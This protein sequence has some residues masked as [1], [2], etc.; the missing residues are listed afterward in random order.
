MAYEDLLPHCSLMEIG[1]RLQVQV[2]ELETVIEI[3]EQLAGEK[4]L[5]GLPI[6]RQTLKESKSRR[7]KE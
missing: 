7:S 5:A 4:D 2:L 3:K 6:L 1:D